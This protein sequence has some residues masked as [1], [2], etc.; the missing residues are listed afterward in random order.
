[1]SAKRL[2][3]QKYS[4]PPRKAKIVMK[5]RCFPSPADIP[6]RKSD[7]AQMTQNRMSVITVTAR[8]RSLIRMVRKMSYKKPAAAPKPRE[9]AASQS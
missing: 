3:V 7:R 9:A 4:V 8:R 6:R 5:I 1:M 2:T